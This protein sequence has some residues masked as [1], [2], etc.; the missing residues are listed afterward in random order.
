MTIS[1]AGHE[2]MRVDQTMLLKMNRT[3]LSNL[4]NEKYGFNSGKF[5]NTTETERLKEFNYF[6]NLFKRNVV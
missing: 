6:K 5:N 1:G 2:K 3:I 4:F